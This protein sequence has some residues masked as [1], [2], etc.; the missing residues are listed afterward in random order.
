MSRI[1]DAPA[2][3]GLSIA[4]DRES[5]SSRSLLEPHDSVDVESNLLRCVVGRGRVKYSLTQNTGFASPSQLAIDG[6]HNPHKSR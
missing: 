3:V 4:E 2:R 5:Y 1:A 6:L